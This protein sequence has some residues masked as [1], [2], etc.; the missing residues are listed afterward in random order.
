VR[1]NLLRSATALAL[2]TNVGGDR[3]AAQQ[4]LPRSDSLLVTAAW[5]QAHLADPDLVLLHV[6]HRMGDTATVE[7]IPGSVEIDYMMIARDTGSAPVYSELPEPDS[8]ASLLEGLGIGADSRVL[9]Y[10]ADPIMA[11]RGF[12]ALEFAG[13]GRV[14][15]LDGG[16]AAWKAG[17]HRVVVAPAPPQRR[18]T[19][20]RRP[21]A[22]IIVD[23]DWIRARLGS[24]SLALVDTRTDGEYL[25]T[26]KRR[27]LPSLG[28]LPGARLLIWQDLI[29]PGGGTSLRPRN[30]LAGL[31]EQAGA[32]PGKTVVT[33][34]YVGYRASLSY[35]VARLLGLDVRFYDGSYNDWSLRGYPLTKGAS[36]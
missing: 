9:L 36:P 17:G 26:G 13:L 22:D 30:E 28:H 19:L 14:H 7:L 20:P 11:A 4:A 5:V 23:A 1:T 24:P 31:F 3:T 8:L 15:V 27:D 16:V 32:V 10:S 33:Y 34:C 35:F 25:G 12:V 18:G 21:R 6:G 2:L 29:A